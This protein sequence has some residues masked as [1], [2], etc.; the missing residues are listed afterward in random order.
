MKKIF[1]LL[2]IAYVFLLAGCSGSGAEED[3][4]LVDTAGSAEADG[5]AAIPQAMQDA[6]EVTRLLFGTFMLEG[7]DLAVTPEQAAELLPLWK[8]YRSL[9]ESDIAAA[10]E[11]EAVAKQLRQTMAAKQL[12]AMEDQEIN[13]EQLNMIME[14]MGVEMTRGTGGQGEAF[15]PPDG[16]VPPDGFSPGQGGGPRGGGNGPGGDTGIDPEMMATRQAT[17]EEGGVFQ[18]GFNLP[19]VEALIK[20]LEGR[21]E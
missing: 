15:T 10:A 12:A 5:I 8:L 9:L 18:R 4:N 2:S 6:T 14:E 7:T 11:I 19:L 21:I 20:L 3:Q 16:M 13:R 17:M 1:I